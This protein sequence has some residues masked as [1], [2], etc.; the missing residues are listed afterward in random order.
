MRTTHEES[1][2]IGL[3]SH[4]GALLV[5]ERDEVGL[6]PGFRSAHRLHLVHRGHLRVHVSIREGLIAIQ[7]YMS[8]DTAVYVILLRQLCQRYE[9]VC[10]E[11]CDT[12]CTEGLQNYRISSSIRLCVTTHQSDMLTLF[13]RPPGL[14]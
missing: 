7:Q 12:A 9:Y 1:N 6:R 2:G 5:H 4:P 3:R 10:C 11:L 14:S 8:S 13:S